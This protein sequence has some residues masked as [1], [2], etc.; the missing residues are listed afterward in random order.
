MNKKS[1]IFISI[2]FSIILIPAIMVGIINYTSE[3][4]LNDTIENSGATKTLSLNNIT[5]SITFDELLEIEMSKEY[6]IEEDVSVDGEKMKTVTFTS[7]SLFG[8]R[9]ESTYIFYNDK[10]GF[11]IIT[12]DT[13]H[14]MSEDILTELISLNGEPDNSSLKK[15]KVGYDTYYWYGKNGTIFCTDDNVSDTIEIRFEIN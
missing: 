9:C 2:F 13:S 12:V 3:Q 15:E 14:C 7:A 11:C 1:K 5:Q 8:S 4:E 10:L 6:S